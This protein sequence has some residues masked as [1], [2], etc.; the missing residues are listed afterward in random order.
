MDDGAQPNPALTAEEQDL[1][2]HVG[3]TYRE[4]ERLEAYHPADLEE[5][6]F[7]VHALGRIVMAR[8]AIRAHATR[9]RPGGGEW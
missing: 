6:A 8:P 7:H 2:D 9:L 1:L 4:F 3:A 5:F